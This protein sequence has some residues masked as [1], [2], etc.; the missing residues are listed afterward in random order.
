MTSEM[1]FSIDKIEEYDS[2]GKYDPDVWKVYLFQ[3]FEGSLEE[4]LNQMISLD[5]NKLFYEAIKYEYGYGVKQDLN[6]ALLFINGK[7]ILYI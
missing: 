6:K 5:E 4:R 3:L 7:T 1:P 2:E